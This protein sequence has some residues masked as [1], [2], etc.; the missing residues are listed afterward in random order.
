MGAWGYK[1][2]ECDEGLDVVGFLRDFI[3]QHKVSNHWTLL[4][5]VQEMKNKGFFGE[6]FEDIDFFYDVSAMALAEVYIQY[7]DSNEFCGVQV[8]IM[9]DEESLIFILRYLQD[10]RDEIPDQ[11]GEREIIEL[12]SE[13]ES[14]PEW[15]SNLAHLIQRIGQE[16]SRLQ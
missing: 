4:N 7:L 8:Q 15:K 2:L 5:I 6:S 14:W 16:I 1:A 13:S 3:E 11:Y 12:W 9:A 10:I